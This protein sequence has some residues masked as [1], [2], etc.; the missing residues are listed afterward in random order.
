MTLSLSTPKGYLQAHA[1]VSRHPCLS[2]S[3]HPAND[4][5]EGA[6]DHNKVPLH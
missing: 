6:L 1:S 4:H 2:V 5:V 3:E